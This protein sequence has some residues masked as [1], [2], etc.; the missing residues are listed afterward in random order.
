LRLVIDIKQSRLNSDVQK[1]T[2][3][4]DLIKGV[5]F[6]Q[7]GVEKVM[8]VLDLINEVPVLITL[9]EDKMEIIIKVNYK[10]AETQENPYGLPALDWRA[11]NILVIIDPGHGG[12]DSGAIGF[13]QGLEVLFEKDI[14]LDISTRLSALL[15]AAGVKFYNIRTDDTSIGL[16]ERPSLANSLNADLYIG[17]HNNSSDNGKAS[18]VEILY[19][20]KENEADYSI[21]SKRMAELAQVELM[22]ELGLP[23]RGIKSVPELAVLNKTIMPAIIIEGGF[24]SNPYDLAFMKNDSFREKY[25]VGAARAILNALN[26]SVANK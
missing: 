6:W 10:D 22:K 7:V 21:K 23:S 8:V 12:K 18:G 1:I 14:N 20:T 11:T 15:S 2:E 5:R 16:Y 9:S 4:N 13:E 26:E 19:Y 25:A 24:L 3:T 17:I